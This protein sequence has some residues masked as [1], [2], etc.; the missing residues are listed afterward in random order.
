[1][2]N[3]EKKRS[4]I[5][6]KYIPLEGLPYY[7]ILYT[8]RRFTQSAKKGRHKTV[9]CIDTFIAELPA[10]VTPLDYY[11]ILETTFIHIFYA[12][13]VT[14]AIATLDDMRKIGIP[15]G[16]GLESRIA[17]YLYYE[18]DQ[19]ELALEYLNADL[20]FARNKDNTVEYTLAYM[21]YVMSFRVLILADSDPHG[22]RL[23]HAPDELCQISYAACYSHEHIATA[24]RILLSLNR[25]PFNCV[26]I[27][28]AI[29]HEL[30]AKVRFGLEANSHCIE[31]VEWWLQKNPD[32]SELG[33]C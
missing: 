18:L 22:Q 7:S 16:D 4:Q 15:D 5:T 6:P 33:N 8:D 9:E 28:Y 10:D 24:I 32:R 12:K 31:E 23:V 26:N 17:K 30:M 11:Y 21:R 1:M 20:R 13:K 27:M 19:I 14:E 3:D 2:S 25:F 29:W